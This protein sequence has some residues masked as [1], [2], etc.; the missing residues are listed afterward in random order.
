MKPKIL[1]MLQ[2]K[3]LTKEQIVKDIIAGIIVAIIALP[4]SIA[5]GISS[6]VSPEK[7]LITAIIAGFFISFLGGSRVQIGGP[8]GAFV[9]I[10]YGIIQ[11]YG[12][13]GLILATIMAGIILVIMGFLKLGSVIKFVPHP[14]TVGFTSGIAIT[15]LSTQI[16]DLLGLK[17]NNVPAEFFEKW[18]SYLT[19]IHSFNLSTFLVG[20]GSLLIIVLW[21]RINKTIPGSLI[22]L[23]IATLAV[24]FLNLPVETI[25]SR[26]GEISSSLP[27]PKLEIVDLNTI[28]EL[29]KPAMTIAILAAIE[30]LLSA[31]VADGMIGGKHDSNME[32]VAQGVANITSG[33]FGGIPATGAIARTAANVK[34]NGRSPIAGMVHAVTLL[35]IMI[36]LMPLAKLIPMTSLAAI[37]IVVSYNMGEWSTFKS[38]LKAPKSD[39]TVLITTFLLTVIFDLVVAIEIGMIFAMCLFMKRVADTTKIKGMINEIRNL[40]DNDSSLNLDNIDDMVLVYEINGPFFFGI[41]HKFMDVMNEIKPSAEVLV[42]D[43]KN[44]NAL[45][46]SAIDAL[47]RLYHR[48][49][50]YK[51]KLLLANI[52]PQPKKVLQKMGFLNLIGKNSIF[53][54]KED[55]LEASLNIATNKPLNGQTAIA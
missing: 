54:S 6:G 28:K 19:N 32:L 52:Q 14:I 51:I 35:L 3:D 22:A 15:L 49:E 37:L 4:L 53:D 42:L 25:G 2:R 23:I 20:L 41:V 34:N 39:V 48:C 44:A 12:L 18:Q 43:M 38:L 9:V 5:L 47:E 10:V 11:N 24:K 45:D 1:R 7:G 13:E 21:P 50:N 26:F 16:K 46:A 36:V 40:E 17:I 8:T 31:V 29:F 33:L 55:A 27:A 30:S